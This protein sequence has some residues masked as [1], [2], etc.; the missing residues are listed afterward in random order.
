MSDSQVTTP[1]TL[2]SKSLA[3][4][5]HPT[6]ACYSEEGSG[7][8][9]SRGKTDADGGGGSGSS[10]GS[11]AAAN[12]GATAEDSPR[13]SA[14]GTTAAASSSVRTP[15][16][17][18]VDM[19]EPQRL[20]QTTCTFRRRRT[21]P[22]LIRCKVN[23]TTAGWPPIKIFISLIPPTQTEPAACTAQPQAAAAGKRERGERGTTTHATSLICPVRCATF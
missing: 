20:P 17:T 10:M 7:G 18:G 2:A 23:K 21:S 6:S 1:W 9:D 8:A 5:G 16:K 12:D 4:R 3:F 14:G 15:S 22:P 19:L 13:A 11:S